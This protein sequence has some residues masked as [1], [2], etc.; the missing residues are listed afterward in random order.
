[1]VRGELES[2]T[3][4]LIIGGHDC[5]VSG[6]TGDGVPQQ[7]RAE[8]R[9][10]AGIGTVKNDMMQTANHAAMMHALTSHRSSAASGDR[11]LERH[12]RIGVP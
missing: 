1:M 2:Q 7:S 10:F 4:A 8:L 11:P 12:R 3:R 5:P 9:E 6:V